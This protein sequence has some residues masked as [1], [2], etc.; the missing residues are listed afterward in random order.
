MADGQSGQQVFAC[1]SAET[2]AAEAF[3]FR[4]PSYTNFW[5]T[6]PLVHIWIQYTALNARNLPYFIHFATTLLFSDVI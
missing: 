3:R 4:F 2:R 5:T 1:V 6:F